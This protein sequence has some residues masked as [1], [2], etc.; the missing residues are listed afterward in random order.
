MAVLLGVC[1][2]VHPLLQSPLCCKELKEAGLDAIQL[3]LGSAEEIFRCRRRAYS[4]NGKKRRSY[5]AS[6]LTL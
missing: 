1:N 3:D 2:W 6:G 4:G 5:T